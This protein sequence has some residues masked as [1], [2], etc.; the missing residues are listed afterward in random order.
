MELLT[1][2]DVGL[3]LSLDADAEHAATLSSAGVGG[4]VQM[5]EDA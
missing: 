3:R 4:V 5:E 1:G 2:G